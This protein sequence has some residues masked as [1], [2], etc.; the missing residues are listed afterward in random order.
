VPKK[1]EAE[2]P[3]R[4][5]EAVGAELSAAHEQ[6]AAL[7]R[8]LRGLP[9]KIRRALAADDAAAVV[10]LRAAG[11]RLAVRIWSAQKARLRLASELASL[12]AEEIAREV[13]EAYQSWQG[14]S[15]KA[16]ELRERAD[17]AELEWHG[18]R[19]AAQ[20]ARSRARE[21][22]SALAE[23]NAAGPTYDLLERMNA[24]EE[25]RS[26]GKPPVRGLNG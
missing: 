25:P 23:L 12:E 20:D 7:T 11:E 24:V 22:G 17:T 2:A 1:T 26:F 21:A 9:E 14:L 10:G 6:E 3:E 4:T 8:E 18:R 5:V 16:R 13:N 19:N 15:G